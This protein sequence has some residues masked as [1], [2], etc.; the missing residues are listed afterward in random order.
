MKHWKDMSEEE[1]QVVL[2]M[3]KVYSEDEDY[4]DLYEDVAIKNNERSAYVGGTN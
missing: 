1:R 4:E 2:Q 3:S